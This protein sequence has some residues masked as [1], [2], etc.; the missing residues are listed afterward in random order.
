[1]QSEQTMRANA[2]AAVRALTNRIYRN[3][4]KRFGEEWDLP[5]KEIAWMNTDDPSYSLGALGIY[6]PEH[7]A[8]DFA[9]EMAR[10][11]AANTPFR[12]HHGLI[13]VMADSQK[14]GLVLAVARDRIPSNDTESLFALN[15]MA[16]QTLCCFGAP[17]LRRCARLSMSIPC[18]TS[19][20]SL[21]PKMQE[22][23]LP[24]R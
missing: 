14:T 21:S 2:N 5:A 1:M 4:K 18:G 23:G 3:F 22:L 24:R 6:R 16:V 12:C 11:I 17:E 15:R 9:M 19:C 13:A 20:A 10:T 8:A 7:P